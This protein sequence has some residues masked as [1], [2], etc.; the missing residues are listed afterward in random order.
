MTWYFIYYADAK[1]LHSFADIEA[2]FSPSW[3]ANMCSD[4]IIHAPDTH[5]LHDI[6]YRLR[7]MGLRSS[8][9][10][11]TSNEHEAMLLQLM[12]DSVINQESD[13]RPP[14]LQMIL[15]DPD[16]ARLTQA[17]IPLD[18]VLAEQD[19]EQAYM[20]DSFNVLRIGTRMATS[21]EELKPSVSQD[22]LDAASVFTA[23]CHKEVVRIQEANRSCAR[24]AKSAR[25][26]LLKELLSYATF[27]LK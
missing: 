15:E 5:R 17:S 3:L 1:Y 14:A 2:C 27:I 23:A 18:D 24:R 7:H 6:G 26:K 8:V 4:T 13:K 19:N 9:I 21:V 25:K 22:F 12:Q 11:Q 20:K 16:F 10:L